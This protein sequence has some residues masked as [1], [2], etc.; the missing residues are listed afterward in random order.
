MADSTDPVVQLMDE[1]ASVPP[2]P[3]WHG[4]TLVAPAAARRRPIGDPP[5]VARP[6]ARFFKIQTSTF[7]MATPLS[8][9]LM[10]PASTMPGPSS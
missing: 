2:L 10:M 7:V 3:P 9:R 8:M 1:R 6:L 5:A 4:H